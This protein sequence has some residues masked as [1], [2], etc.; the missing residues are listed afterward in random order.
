VIDLPKKLVNSFA[1]LEGIPI[2][3][4]INQ[5]KLI[6]NFIKDNDTP[7]FLKQEFLGGIFGGDG[8]TVFLKK[9][10]NGNYCFSQCKFSQSKSHDKKEYLKII[11][12]EMI[13]I[14]NQLGIKNVYYN[15]LRE[16][17][18]SKT[19]T[20]I[21]DKTYEL[22]LIIPKESMNNFGN[23][24]GF[25]YCLHKSMRLNIA[26]SYLNY[27]KNKIQK[28]NDCEEWLK[29]TNSHD[30]MFKKYAIE[31]KNLLISYFH[32][33]ITN[34][35]SVGKKKVYD[36]TIDNTHNFIAS[37]IVVHNCHGLPI[38]YEIEKELGIKTTQ[39][40][41]EY[42]IGNYNEACRGIV[43]KYAHEWEHQMGRLGRWIDFT[44]DYK[45]MDKSFMNAVWWVF[46]TLYDKERVY[47]GVKIMGYSTTCGT[48]LSNFEIQQNYQEVQDDSLFIK[49]PI[50]SSNPMYKD[51]SILVWTT[52][53]WTLPSNYAL[54]VGRSI[55][56][57]VSELDG[58]RYIC[59]EKLIENIFQKKQLVILNK[60][61][62]EELIG[63]EYKPPF[64]FNTCVIIL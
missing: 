62:G 32:T 5:D 12:N 15:E 60:I 21:E 55:D 24:I 63:L 36:I 50:C 11:Y 56:Y 19:K 35:K 8:H 49:L 14:M 59:G 29:K 10:E 64:N 6:P 44:N 7:I 42:G 57:V 53:P 27:D 18:I 61:K 26:L 3:K 28:N 43:N 4:R 37:G 1:L 30:I 31:R 38:E 22:T 34:V 16:T 54:C 9:Y 33:T 2:G 17:T 46:K 39:Q 48:P 52:T 41:E 20:N 58:Q 13:T 25:R 40:V 23:M 47:E 51:T 45:T